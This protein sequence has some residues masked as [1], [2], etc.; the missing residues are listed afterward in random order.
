MGLDDVRRSWD[1]LARKDAL[2]AVLS[3]PDKRRGR[4]DAE[5]FFRTGREEV[6][7]VLAEA[8]GL[9]LVP[10][11]DLALD[12]GCGVGR[13]AQAMGD[14]FRSV[15]G[16][17]IA[18]SMIEL[19][20]RFN[21]H[22]DRCR[23]VVND[24]PDLALFRDGEFDFVYSNIVLQHIPPP[25]GAGYIREFVR[26]LRPGG[27]LVFQVPSRLVG[28][29]ADAPRS[30]AE[31]PLPDEAFRA[32][33]RPKARIPDSMRPGEQV[34]VHVRVTNTSHER[35]PAGAAPDG[36][37]RI[38]VGNHWVAEDG[39]VLRDDGRATLPRDVG[40][41][42]RVTVPLT[43]HTPSRPGTYTLE[44]DLVQEEVAWFEDKG[45]E[46]IRSEVSVRPR[47]RDR[48]RRRQG[49]PESSPEGWVPPRM[50]MHAIP[51]DE[52]QRIV[53]G[54]GGRCV[55]ATADRWAGEEW[56]SFR[57]FVTRVRNLPPAP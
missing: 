18:P 9:G 30:P 57:Y 43:V 20:E 10:G 5:S 12:F 6:A 41:G 47:L 42:Q 31:G 53:D 51:R 45:V 17:D 54:S 49:A 40:P 25:I 14:R 26:V 44:I 1:E 19:A 46:P 4:W 50:Q 35:W 21:R 48:L 55:A 13:L 27:L 34:T 29:G 15:V 39:E 23:Y 16:V 56:E 2:W 24:R 33:I 36:R 32:R 8:E 11:P 7:Q 28:A 22:G 38:N 52:V 37:F 3:A